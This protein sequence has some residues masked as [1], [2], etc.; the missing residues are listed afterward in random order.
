LL[1]SYG[2]PTFFFPIADVIRNVLSTSLSYF[3]ESPR[4]RP[5]PCFSL[6]AS[7]FTTLGA[8]LRPQLPLA[9]H[10]ALAQ[11]LAVD[12]R[13]WPALP[14][15]AWAL[16]QDDQHRAATMLVAFAVLRRGPVDVTVTSGNER[17]GAGRVAA[18]GAARRLLC[19][20][21]GLCR[22]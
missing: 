19:R 13:L 18:P 20:R 11:L 4:F 6:P 3:G 9:E 22:L 7:F 21:S 10:A 16:W 17:V 12:G 15:M 1:L 5:L 14:H 8:R 2:D